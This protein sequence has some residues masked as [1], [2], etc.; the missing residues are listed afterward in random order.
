MLAFHSVINLVV[1]R[2]CT[3]QAWSYSYYLHPAR[4]AVEDACVIDWYV[5]LRD[6]LDDFLCDHTTCQCRNIVQL[7]AISAGYLLSRLNN[8]WR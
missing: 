5:L 2:H 1:V 6:D 7:T 3:F 8:S 4:D